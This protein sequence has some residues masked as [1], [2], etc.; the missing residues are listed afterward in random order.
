M[1]DASRAH[2]S[3]S[4]GCSVSGNFQYL[5]THGIFVYY[6]LLIKCIQVAIPLDY[7]DLIYTHQF[8]SDYL[9]DAGSFGRL[10]EDYFMGL[11]IR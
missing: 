8:Y 6:F 11:I 10:L 7:I 9:W 5:I 4:G 1:Y 3:V 2:C